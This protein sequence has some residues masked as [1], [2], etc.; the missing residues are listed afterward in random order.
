VRKHVE[1][2]GCYLLDAVQIA[3][4]CRDTKQGLLKQCHHVSGCK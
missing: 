4:Q 3:L 1:A 2:G